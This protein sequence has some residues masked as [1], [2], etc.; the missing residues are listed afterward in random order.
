[1]AE[2]STTADTELEDA[3]DRFNGCP[4]D[5]DFIEASKKRNENC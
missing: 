1:M 2:G 5:D 4:H 3:N